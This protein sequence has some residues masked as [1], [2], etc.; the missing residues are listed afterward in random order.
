MDFVC[1]QQLINYKYA[2]PEVDV[3]S[4]A[5]LFYF[6]LSGLPPRPIIKKNHPISEILETDPISI[7]KRRP[8]LPEGLVKIIDSALDD[9]KDLAYKTAKRLKEE[10]K[11]F[12]G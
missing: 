1:R 12:R 10:L 7:S 9:R 11:R 3:W 5:A 8:N 2:K 6:L 4:T